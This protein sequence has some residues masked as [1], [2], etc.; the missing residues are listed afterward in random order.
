ME[1]FSQIIQIIK[2]IQFSD[3]AKAKI[4]EILSRIESTNTLTEE[5]KNNL[6][7]IIK[8]DMVLDAIDIKEQEGKLEEYNKLLEELNK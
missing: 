8:G 6:L 2:G 1:N 7:D 5:D 3:I 4:D